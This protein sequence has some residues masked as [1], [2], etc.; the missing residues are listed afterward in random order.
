VAE[1]TESYYTILAVE[2]T[3]DAD[4]IAAAIKKS[5]NVWTSRMS[6]PGA[7]GDKARDYV[8]WINDAETILLDPAKR[9]SYDQEL[10][11]GTTAKNNWAPKEDEQNWLDTAWR[12][13]DENDMELAQA[14]AR[15]ATTQQ[16]KNATAWV[17]AGE[18]HKLRGDYNS[19]NEAAYEAVLVDEENPWAYQ[20]R[21]DVYL[22]KSENSQKA[23]EQ[24]QKME[25]KAH[26]NEAVVRA[27]RG[28]QA[29]A[30]SYTLDTQVN[31]AEAALPEGT[32]AYN[33]AVMQRLESAKSKLTSL[34]GQYAS[35]LN[36]LGT[37]P[38]E[39]AKDIL[40]NDVKG[41]DDE[42]REVD[43]LIADGNTRVINWFGF[44]KF[45]VPA[46]IL[47]IIG[48]AIGNA[49]AVIVCLLIGGGLGALGWVSN[50]KPKWKW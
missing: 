27:A 3:A 14:A 15:K 50:S 18:I 4:D 21:G 20:L 24:Y 30:K 7:L 13:Y 12:Y 26:G 9:A 28:D 25:Q 43:R 16:P 22:M 29:I 2:P 35:L 49:G 1:R 37:N 17:L 19:A 10:A 48:I 45:L 11:G 5:R 23:L 39:R 33:E 47:V 32:F 8:T 38:D 40:S 34:R 46:I 42:I 44:I 41:L 31:A 6:R 36:D